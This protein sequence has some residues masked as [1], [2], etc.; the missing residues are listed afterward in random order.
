MIKIGFVRHGCTAWNKERRSQ[1]HSDIPLDN[2]G[3]AQ[4]LRLAD[5]LSEEDWDIIYSS[6]LLRASQ[7]AE[8]I[9]GKL[10]D[11]D[12]LPDPRL[13]EVSGGKIEGTTEEERIEKWGENWREL[14]M[15]IET[16]DKVIER[17]SE[18]LNEIVQKHDGQKVLIVSHGSYI[19]HMLKELLPQIDHESLHN[20]SLTTL[21]RSSDKWEVGLHNCTK[22]LA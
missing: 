14:D 10:G 20:C 2:E 18:F 19:K 6:N 7:T 15:G 17:G 12:V 5:R 4:A 21:Q 8:I 3:R 16:A 11:F 13:R 1:G 22:H 9:S